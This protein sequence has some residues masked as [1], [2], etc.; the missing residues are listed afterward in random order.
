MGIPE[1]EERS[2]ADS[3]SKKKPSEL[4]APPRSDCSARAALRKREKKASLSAIVAESYVDE[5]TFVEL[6]RE[7]VRAAKDARRLVRESERAAIAERTRLERE[8]KDRAARIDALTET[9]HTERYSSTKVE[10]PIETLIGGQRQT[11]VGPNDLQKVK[12]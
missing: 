1:E 9:S 5:N 2:P 3:S 11:K 8:A 4:P 12:C 7:Q 6:K 10:V